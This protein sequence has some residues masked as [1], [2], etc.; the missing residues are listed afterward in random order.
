MNLLSLG[1]VIK[2]GFTNFWRNWWLSLVAT[3]IMTLT[4]LIISI[5][6]I[7]NIVINTTTNSIKEKIDLA[8]YFKIDTPEDQVRLVQEKLK[9]RLDVKSIHFVS[10]EEALKR[11][12]EMKISQKI[13]EQIS[14]QDNPLPFSL[15]VKTHRSEDLEAVANY[16]AGPEFSQIVDRISY[17]EN[18][19]IIEKLVNFTNFSRKLGLALGLVFIVISILVILNTVRLAIY[20]RT[21]EI[22]I[23]RL[24]GA[25]DIFIRVPF[26]I[27]ALLYSLLA[28][29]LSMLFIWIG[30]SFISPMITHYLGDINLDMKGFFIHNLSWIFL[31]ELIISSFISVSCSII[32]MGKHL[33][34]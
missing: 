15:D 32:S 29:L 14:T 23:M 13:K 7:F 5:F 34:I 8:V 1:R 30:L 6:I 27:E 12:Q 3:L 33:K 19:D 24:V 22:E 28:T 18:K 2:L 31:F 20:T 11:W 17:K 21:K 26:I 10:K 16:L 4:L 25:S 9:N